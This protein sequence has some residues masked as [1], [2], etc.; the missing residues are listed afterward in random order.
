[1][2]GAL[3][4]ALL[5]VCAPTA[6]AED[7]ARTAALR[8]VIEYEDLREASP[9][10]WRP[11]VL[12]EDEVVRRHA[13]RAAGRTRDP[14]LAPLLREALVPGRY[15]PE[16]TFALELCPDPGSVD[17]LLALNALNALGRLGEALPVS[18]LFPALDQE[19]RRAEAALLA[20]CRLRGRRAK[21]SEPLHPAVAEALLKSLERLTTRH[22]LPWQLAYAVAELEALDASGASRWRIL[23]RLTTARASMQP[24]AR[25]FVA[26][27]LGSA[28]GPGPE[29]AGLLLDLLDPPRPHVAAAVAASI[30]R[31]GSDCGARLPAAVEQLAALARLHGTPADFH[32]RRA[33]VAA[34]TDLA[35]L[36]GHDEV[37]LHALPAARA[38]LD[39]PSPSVRID[40]LVALARL[41][42]GA[43]EQVAARASHEH[44]LDRLAAARAARHLPAAT[45]DPLLERLR[46]DTDVRVAC[47]ALTLLGALAGEKDDD[48][49]ARA[50]VAARAA[51]EHPDLAVRATGVSLLGEHGGQGDVAAIAAV[52]SSS[53]GA[54]LVEVR[55]ECV[56][57]LKALAGREVAQ[58]LPALR[59]TLTDEAPAVR[60]AAAE[61]LAALTGE[62]ITLPPAKPTRSTVA[63]E[64]A[65]L[66][67]DAERPGRGPIVILHT[68][69]GRIGIELLPV[70]APR[71]VKGFLQRARAGFYDGLRF[72]RVVTGFVVQGL[73][74]RGDGWG[75]GGVLVKDE[76]NPVPYLAGAVGM[77]N[78]GPDTG[79][80]QL[81][82]THVPTPHLDGSYTV[83]GRVVDGMNVVHALDLDDVCERVEV[84]GDD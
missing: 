64:P 20:I 36:P 15:Q 26:R 52:A 56:G 61:A 58:A 57:A 25:L 63:L 5:L 9:E 12:H 48:A 70:E 80:C 37:R 32:A 53:P 45:R 34:L 13:V 30:A 46:Q 38:A 65:D 8:Q 60:K 7:D 83:F 21:V 28:P 74:P 19:G 14:A 35:A 55:V 54:D 73:D 47:E 59:A 39:D 79:G 17:V 22:D 51:T 50:V 68:T 44:P 66:L 24:D 77:P 69:K 16:L 33:A 27:A 31:I 6:R 40:A 76:I 41:D 82:I 78:A 11:L 49:R 43:A 72:H 84:I 1:M 62:A 4:I 2:R 23:K 81:F 18:A 67:R 10:A 42:P 29:R 3:A 71:H 75:S